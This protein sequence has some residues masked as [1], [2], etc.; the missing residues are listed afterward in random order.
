[1]RISWHVT[2]TAHPAKV[3][4]DD[5]GKFGVRRF[6]DGGAMQ[7]Q[8][9]GGIGDFGKFA[10]LRHLMKDR[11]LAVCCYLTGGKYE[12]KDRERHLDYLERPEDFR[13][14][15]PE[16]FDRLAAFDDGVDDPLAKLQASGILGNA[17]FLRK[18]VPKRVSVRRLWG[19]ELAASVGS[20]DLVFLDPDRGI[21]GKRLTNRHVALAEIKALRL[22]GRAL[23]IG[24]RPSG[25]KSEVKFLADQMH[26]LGCDPVE[27][28]RL[29]LFSS[30]L[31]VI[32]DHDSAMTASIAT[33]ARKWGA[34]AKSYRAVDGEARPGIARRAY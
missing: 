34:R 28:I 29:R 19:H 31:Y 14:F 4:P 26:S 33:F 3:S 8:Y 9:L 7:L 1:L 2:F 12:T 17:V 22:P 24:H 25:R 5:G 27:I 16:V 23:I 6:T 32:A 15:A 13:H 10:L 30:H 11:R 21:E 20:A 18:E